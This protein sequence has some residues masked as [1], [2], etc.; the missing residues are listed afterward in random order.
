MVAN[1]KHA[2]DQVLLDGPGADGGDDARAS[3]RQLNGLAGATGQVSTGHDDVHALRKGMTLLDLL[4]AHGP[5]SMAELQRASGLNRTMT[6]RLLRALSEA[7]YV[8]HDPVQKRYALGFRLLQLGAAVSDR[9]EIVTL[10]RPLLAALRD[11]TEETVNLGVLDGNEIVYLA[12]QES[13]LGLRMAARLGG[14]D[15]AHSTSLGKA[16]LAYLPATERE[17][18]VESLL[19]LRALTP[20]TL[21]EPES[22]A[23]DLARTRER[24]HALDDEENEVGARCVGVPVLDAQ[25]RPLA[26]LSV[27]GPAGRIDLEGMERIATRLWEASRELSRRMGQTGDDGRRYA[28]RD[29]RDGDRTG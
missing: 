21:I 4:A 18:V 11:E 25:G 6:F 14:R 7:G 26:G 3:P 12:M 29:G 27:S 15:P 23:H 10:A 5:M 28:A 8:V 19:P 22:L 16:I 20:A 9:L 1:M 17:R 24:G 13:P 2:Q